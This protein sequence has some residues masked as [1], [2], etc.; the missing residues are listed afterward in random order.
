MCVRV[1]LVL[2]PLLCGVRGRTLYSGAPYR[3]VRTCRRPSSF[4]SSKNFTTA[5]RSMEL[6]LR[7]AIM[8][9]VRNTSSS[10]RRQVHG[11]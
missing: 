4:M 10:T 2:A 9:C 5:T 6:H 11:L 8:S 7:V 3:T 1:L